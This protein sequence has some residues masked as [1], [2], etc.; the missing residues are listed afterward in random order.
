MTERLAINPEYVVADEIWL[1]EKLRTPVLH[2]SDSEGYART[3]SWSPGQETA[4]P[5]MDFP[6]NIVGA[7]SFDYETKTDWSE[8]E[9]EKLLRSRGNDFDAV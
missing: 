5:I 4:P 8:T 6:E 1:D 9:I 3:D 2:L 7:S